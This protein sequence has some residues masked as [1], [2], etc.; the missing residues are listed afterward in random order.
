EQ[1]DRRAGGKNLRHASTRPRLPDLDPQTQTPL[2]PVPKP[3]P[4]DLAKLAQ[5]DN[6]RTSSLRQSQ[7]PKVSIG[8]DSSSLFSVGCF[9]CNDFN[10]ASNLFVRERRA[11]NQPDSARSFWNCG[12]ANRLSQNTRF[13]EAPR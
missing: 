7:F 9:T 2:A 12:R 10:Q 1:N 6:P 13:A 11:K 8:D 5:S 3:R 4:L